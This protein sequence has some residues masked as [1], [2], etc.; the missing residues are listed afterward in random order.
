MSSEPNIA[1]LKSRHLKFDSLMQNR[2]KHILL[3]SSPYDSFVLE[4][5][6]QLSNLIYNEYL[7][8]N[9]TVTPHIK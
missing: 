4:E 7:E 6:G 8:L 3:V 1:Q 2:I 5:D 9:L